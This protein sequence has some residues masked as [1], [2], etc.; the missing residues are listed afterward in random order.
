MVFTFH[1]L[2]KNV[3]VSILLIVCFSFVCFVFL[4]KCPAIL[5]SGLKYELICGFCF[6]ADDELLRAEVFWSGSPLGRYLHASG[7][8]T[9][10]KD[11]EVATY[12]VAMA[13]HMLQMA[14]FVHQVWSPFGRHG[15]LTCTSGDHMQTQNF[16]LVA[17]W[18]PWRPRSTSG[19]IGRFFIRMLLKHNAAQHTTLSSQNSLNSKAVART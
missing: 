14:T 18:S 3:R 8:L 10:M 12:M 17:I 1:A 4:N 5:D 9:Y 7:D 13:T 11:S 19:D 16:L 15:D 6:V 2:N